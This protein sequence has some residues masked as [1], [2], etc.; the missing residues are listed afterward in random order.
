MYQLTWLRVENLLLS[1]ILACIRKKH[2]LTIFNCVFIL[3]GPTNFYSCREY[4]LIRHTLLRYNNDYDFL[5]L[6]TIL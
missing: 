2:V 3:A 5:L 6:L 1:K 4:N